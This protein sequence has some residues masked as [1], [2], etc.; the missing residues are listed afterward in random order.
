MKRKIAIWLIVSLTAVGIWGCGN[1]EADENLQKTEAVK[2]PAEEKEAVKKEV[3]SEEKT[4]QK[5]YMAPAEK[6]TPVEAT[7]ES[8]AKIGEW[9]KTMKQSS[10]DYQYHTVY[11]RV[12]GVERD[13]AKVLAAVEEADTLFEPET[14]D[15]H[16]E[17]CM[18]TYEVYFPEDYPQKE[19]GIIDTDISFY[20]ENPDG[21][22]CLEADGGSFQFYT[23]G[24]CDITEWPEVYELNAGEVF[25]EGKAVFSMI[26][27]VSD[28]VLETSYMTQTAEKGEAYVMGQ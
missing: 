6:I 26:K 12:T 11:Y 22:N 16:L 25:T 5:K 24:V 10:A 15:E 19:G 23:G 14:L 1:R 8:P 4:V 13:E 2:G 18:L 27:D 3:V 20:I 28:Y 21:F 7:L 9:V 17:Y